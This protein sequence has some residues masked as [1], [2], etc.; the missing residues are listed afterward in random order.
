MSRFIATARWPRLA[1]SRNRAPELAGEPLRRARAAL[2]AIAAGPDPF[3]AEA[4]RAEF[5]A[6]LAAG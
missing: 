1:R 3:D 5:A 2:A 4:G 6:L